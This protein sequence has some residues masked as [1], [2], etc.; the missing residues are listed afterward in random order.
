M[1]VNGLPL[2]GAKIVLLFLRLH[3]SNAFQT[4]LL[5]MRAT[6]FLLREFLPTVVDI[7]VI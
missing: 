5:T 3:P 4:P 2:K 6:P 7:M 1:I